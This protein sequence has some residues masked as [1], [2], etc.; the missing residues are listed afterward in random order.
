MRPGVLTVSGF[1]PT[2]AAQSVMDTSFLWQRRIASDVI[3]DHS[4]PV[5]NLKA[6]IGIKNGDIFQN[7][8]PA[9]LGLLTHA[10]WALVTYLIAFLALRRRG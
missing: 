7:P 3:T 5:A 9:A 6:R 8:R 2:F 1:M 4:L 10:L